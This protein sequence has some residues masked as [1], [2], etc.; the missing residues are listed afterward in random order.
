MLLGE[1]GDDLLVGGSGRDLLIGGTGADR[2]VGNADDDILISGYTDYDS[3]TAAL[4]AIML[5]WT[6]ERSYQVRCDNIEA[7]VT[8]EMFYLKAEADSNKPRTVHDDN[9]TDSLTGSAGLDWFFANLFLDDEDQADRKDKVTDLHASEF[10]A[11]L[12][13]ILGL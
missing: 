13:W 7:G 11:D 6:S 4:Q 2:I 12:D 8:E 5:E 1:D 3:H 9:A 10:A